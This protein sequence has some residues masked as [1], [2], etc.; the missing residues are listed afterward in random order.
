MEIK[1]Y[2]KPPLVKVFN[3]KLEALR[4]A[5]SIL[6]IWGHATLNNNMLD[7]AYSP[8][9]NWF[10]TGTGHLSVLVFFVLSGYVIGL[11]HPL[12]LTKYTIGDYVKKRLIRIYPIY[13]M[14][15][16]LALVASNYDFP[17]LATIAGH[18]TM[19]QGISTPIISAISPS[20]SLVYEIIFYVLF[21]PISIFRLNPLYVALLSIVIGC[22]NAYFAHS[23]GSPI[24]PSYAFGFV[25]WL[26]GLVLSRT[27]STKGSPIPYSYLLSCLFLFVAIDKLDAPFTLFH[28]IGILLFGK[29]LSVLSNYNIGIISFRDLAYLPYC[30]LILVIFTDKK[31]AYTKLTLLLF[32]VLPIFTFWYYYEHLLISNLSSILLPTTAYALAFSCFAFAGRVEVGAEFLI[33]KLEKTGSISYGLYIVHCPILFLMSQVS[34]FSGTPFTYAIRMLCFLVLSAWAAFM[35]EK[36]FQPWIKMKLY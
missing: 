3:Y 2:E 24:L 17:S 16:L 5:A 9:D 36:R 28:R 13:F 20:W 27:F 30:L 21:I 34:V 15:L 12:A 6:V 35:L 14:C 18:V 11:A 8:V 23:Y 31:L 7:P 4:G 22:V 1:L 26:S 25:F 19:T 33:K 29:D 10:H 32:I